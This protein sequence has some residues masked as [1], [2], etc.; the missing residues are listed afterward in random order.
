PSVL[1]FH[2]GTG[3]Q[4]EGCSRVKDAL[5]IEIDRIVPDPHQPR[6]EFEPAELTELA[7]SLKTRGQLQ[8]IRVR[9]DAALGKWVIIAGE[10]RYRAALEAGLPTLLCIEARGALTPDDILE[11]QLVEN[12]LRVDL[13]PIEQ[14]RAF[15]ALMDR[16]GWSYRQLAENLHIGLSAVARAVALLEL[17]EDLQSQVDAGAVPASAAYEVSRVEDDTTR[18]AIF[19][20][21]AA[22][23]MTRDDVVQ[24]VRQ[25]VKRPPRGQSHA[26]GR[27]APTVTV[28]VFQAAGCKVTVENRRGLDS[29]TLRAALTE[30]LGQIDTEA[31]TVEAE[32]FESPA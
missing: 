7:A 11:D 22:G 32:Q 28:R 15:R 18:R 4:Y 2:G 10:R 31:Y 29:V 19:Q 21:V 23:E 13:K 6:K 14:A 30:A 12:C 25:V 1:A 17:P 3:G 5:A 24:A 8:P 9:W 27:G 20:K 16:R 26:K